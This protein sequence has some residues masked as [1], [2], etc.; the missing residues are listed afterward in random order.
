MSH[1]TAKWSGLKCFVVPHQCDNLDQVNLAYNE[2]H[3]R[4]PPSIHLSYASI[5]YSPNKN[6]QQTKQRH[7]YATLKQCS[8]WYC[9]GFIR[10]G[11]EVYI[12]ITILIVKMVVV[13]FIQA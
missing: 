13:E 1:P 12:V 3:T 6:I 5:P 11:E 4:P 10:V 8:L 7:F 2:P 9:K